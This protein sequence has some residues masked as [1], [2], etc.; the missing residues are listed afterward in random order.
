MDLDSNRCAF[1]GHEI[2]GRFENKPGGWG[3]RRMPVALLGSP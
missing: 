2:A 1:C 3:A